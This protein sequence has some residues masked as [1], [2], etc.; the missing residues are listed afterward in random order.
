MGLPSLF[1]LEKLRIEAYRDVDRGKPADPPRMEVMFN[2]TSLERSHEV[3]YDSATL[4]GLNTPGRPARYA[5]TPP[6]KLGLKLV[7]DGTGV[8]RIG[9]SAMLDPPSVRKDI[10]RF[11]KLCLRMNG[12]IHEPHFLRVR[13]GEFSFDCRLKK[14]DI[15]Y[16]LFD[17][18]GDPLRAELD[19]Q[20]VEDKSAKKIF[21]EAGKNSPDLTHARVVKAGDTLP[22]LCHE[23]YGSSRHY[24]K[25][26][27]DNGLDDFRVLAPG[28][29][30][31]FKPLLPAAGAGGAGRTAS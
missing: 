19:V 7:F 12:D 23:I 16:T 27:R 10:A 25:V 18:S 6:G 9:L 4:Q 3:A 8:D 5:Y 22:L 13:W 15:R 31:L 11:E 28:M 14:L 2:P 29:T 1:K 24:L 20:L 21:R 17:E 26:A 30:L